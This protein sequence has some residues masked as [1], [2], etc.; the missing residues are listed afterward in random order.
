MTGSS[1]VSVLS[2]SILLFLLHLPTFAATHTAA[3]CSL[4]AVQA[5]VN[6]ASD[7]DTVL[8]PNG[9]CSW[10]GGINTTKQIIIQAQNYTPTTG[11]SASRS[12]IITNNSSS[13]LFSLQSGSNYHVGV[14]GIRFNEGTGNG[15]AIRFNGSGSKVPLLFDCYFQNKSRFGSAA[16]V[17]VI[18]WLAQGGVAWN[19]IIDGT[20]FGSGGDPGPSI[21]S[22]SVHFKSPRGWST[23]STLGTRDSNGTV[24]VYFEDSQF[25]NTGGGDLDDNARVVMRHST[26]D[27]SVWIT[28]G[29]TSS[30]GGRHWEA[31]N[32]TYQ[33]TGALRN[34][35]GRYFWIRAGHGVFTDNVVN[36]ASTPQNYGSVNLFDIGDNTSP[37]SYPMPRQPGWGH[38]GTT[39][40]SDPIYSWNNTGARA[41]SYGLQNGWDSIVKVGRD[42]FVNSG[43]KPGY[44]KYIYP[45]PARAGMG[46][47][48]PA[49]TTPP[50]APASLTATPVSSSQISLTWSP[51][52]D[53]VGVTQYIVESCQGSTCSN[54]TQNGTSPSTSYAATGL[55]AGLA[56]RFRVRA[57]DAAGNFS[58]YSNIVS[59]STQVVSDTTAPTTPSNLTAS[60]STSSQISLTWSPSSDAVGVTQYRIESC[61]GS[62]CT[63]FGQI[64]TAASTSYVASGLTAA[65]AYRFRVRAA[66]AAGNLSGYSYIATA[67]TQT[68]SS[69]PSSLPTGNNGIAA[70][71][72]GDTNIQ[73]HPDVLFAD[74]FETYGTVSQLTSNWKSV[75]QTAYTR[76]ATESANVFAGSKAIE[77]RVPQQSA[78]VANALVRAVSPAEDTLFIRVYTKFDSGYAVSGSN[79]NGIVMMSKYSNPGVPAN[80]TNKFAIG[81]E[82]STERPGGA[83]PGY[84]NLYVYQPEQR[85]EWGD[86]WYSDGTVIPYSSTPGD[87]GPNFISRPNFVPD[88]NRWYSYELMV[89][90][91]TPGQRDGRI[92]VW[93]DGNLVA[94]FLNVRLRDIDSLK[95]DEFWLSFHIGNNSIRQ[96]LK[97]Y[98]NVVVARSY[99]GPMRS[100][101]SQPPAPPTN[102]QTIV[103]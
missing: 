55:S 29:F 56:Y 48:R 23:A 52:T 60:G 88:L 21:A 81:L 83:N 19:L 50:T 59:A 32:N 65:T 76:L 73:S 41:N 72:P 18:A 8:I 101:A 97:W 66:D 103:Q 92:A 61:Q 62:S 10:N 28:H 49:D 67:S 100:G 89:K 43:A 3:S 57:T 27:G 53:A 64:G 1:R 16:D 71:Y 37:G 80:G 102:L 63:N 33:V 13:P 36:N 42:V 30:S 20:G 99:I 15:N 12:V 22:V 45:H 79:H 82:N 91:N 74:G 94:D 39:N 40:V 85:S 4:S 38:D 87:F 70:G 69:A 98:D 24:N 47:T 96:N 77:F 5:A 6:A 51:S 25:I 75:T 95:I 17:A 34:H 31:Y 84:T 90:A 46:T 93:I 86:H 11:G 26:F 2:L 14:G 58:S 7:G 44:S 78:E 9:S 35:A 54:F 68:G